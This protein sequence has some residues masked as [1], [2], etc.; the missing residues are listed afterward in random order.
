MGI[1]RCCA[2]ALC[3]VNPSSQAR[4]RPTTRR[5]KSKRKLHIVEFIGTFLNIGEWKTS[6]DSLV[7]QRLYTFPLIG[8]TG[9]G[10]SSR[11]S[12]QELH[13][14]VCRLEMASKSTVKC[15]DELCINTEEPQI[16]HI[17]F[18]VPYL[19]CLC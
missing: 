16:L 5:E 10:V 14:V 19:Q 6:D 12:I 15:M 18:L 7:S 3:D 4:N 17:S 1:Q 13:P 8:Y 2:S 9:L 11:S